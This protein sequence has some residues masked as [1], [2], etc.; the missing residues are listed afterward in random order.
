LYFDIS[1]Y[2]VTSDKRV[3]KAIDFL[4]SDQ[5]VMG[6]DTPYG[7]GNLTKNITRIKNLDISE[8]EKDL[9][10]GENMKRLLKL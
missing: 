5:I 1:T 2:Q 9:I 4:G 8:Q 10:L 3:L 6:S 7:K